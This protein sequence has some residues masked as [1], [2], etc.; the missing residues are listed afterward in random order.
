MSGPC[1][2]AFARGRLAPPA[3]AAIAFI[4]TAAVERGSLLSAL[5][6]KTVEDRRLQPR[7][8]MDALLGLIDDPPCQKPDRGIFLVLQTKL[9]AGA[10][11]SLAHDVDH[12]WLENVAFE[13]WTDRHGGKPPTCL[14]RPNPARYA[15]F[16]RAS[17]P[18]T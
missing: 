15:S 11:Q 8:I 4:G 7:G 3:N 17:I 13:K 5:R 1:Q 2:V 16:V 10:R 12:L 14:R 18:E 9:A 6:A